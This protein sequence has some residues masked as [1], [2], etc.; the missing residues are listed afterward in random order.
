M[1]FTLCGKSEYL[2]SSFGLAGLELQ[3]LLPLHFKSLISSFGLSV[4]VIYLGNLEHS[5]YAEKK[6]SHGFEGIS[7]N[8]IGR[9]WYH[10]P[11]LYP[12]Q[13]SGD[14]QP[15]FWPKAN[16]TVVFCC[17]S[18]NWSTLFFLTYF[19]N[20]IYFTCIFVWLLPLTYNLWKNRFTIW[21]TVFQ[22]VMPCSRS[23]RNNYLLTF[24]IIPH[25]KGFILK[26]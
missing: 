1:I 21:Y 23:S 25:G 13:H 24:Y 15:V 12:F 2:P 9:F 10:S 18:F 20:H 16:K 22:H 6:V 3:I 17:F 4:I 19:L 5:T 7:Q 8:F 26:S 11:L 14:P